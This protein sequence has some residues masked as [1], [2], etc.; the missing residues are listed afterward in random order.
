VPAVRQAYEL[1]KSGALGKNL[2]LS[3]GIFARM[4]YA[5]LQHAKDMAIG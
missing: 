3:R 5:A 1:I 4:D 2:P